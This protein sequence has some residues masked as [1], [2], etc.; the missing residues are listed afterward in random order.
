MKPDMDSKRPNDRDDRRRA[1]EETDQSFIMEASAGTG[2]THTLINRILHLILEKGP[3]GRPLRLLEIC[4]ITFTEKAA[5]E[6][7][8]RLRQYL[9]QKLPEYRTAPVYQER[10]RQALEDLEI[11]SISTFHAFAVGLL[12]ERPIEA[13]L[14][15]RFSA[16]DEIQSEFYFRETWESWISRMLE[17]RDPVLE[18]ALRNGLRLKNLEALARILRLHWIAIRD[19]K[20]ATPPSDEEFCGNLQTIQSRS[21]E[22]VS[23]I[24]DPEDKLARFL[25]KTMSWLLH[26]DPETALDKPGRLGAA[27]KWHGGKDTVERVQAFLREVMELSESY[28]MLPMQRLLDEVV[29]WMIQEFVKGEWEK[30]KKADGYL[31]FDDQLYQARELLRHHSSVRNDFQDRYRTLLVDEFQDTDSIQ[32]EIVLLLSSKEPWQGDAA[33]LLP[34]PGRLF[35][36]GDP[37]QSIYRFRNADIETYLGFVDENSLKTKRIEKVRL[38]ANFRSVPSILN[39]VDAAFEKAMQLPED[40]GKYQPPYA[41]FAGQGA[42]EQDPHYPAVHLLNDSADRGDTKKNV[43]EF[44]EAEAQRIAKLIARVCGSGSWKIQ[45]SKDNNQWRAPQFGDIAI[46]LPVLSHADILEDE[47]CKQNIPYVL[48]GGKFYY[49]RS[50]VGSAITVLRAVSNPNDHVA[51]YGALRSIF[52]G[53]SDEDLL[54]ARMEGLELDYRAPVPETSPLHPVFEILRD[55]HRHR[56]ERRASETFEVLLQKTG[57][58]EV[59]AVRGYQTLAN[60]N[61]VGRTLRTLQGDAAFSQ[62]IDLLSSMDE[63]GLAESESRLMEERSEA[64]RMMSIHKSK[65][66]DFPIVIVAS[67]GLKKQSRAKAFLTDVHEGKIFSLKIGS[68]ESGLQMA[69]WDELTEKEKKREEAELVRLL[70]VGLTRARDHLILS[71][72]TGGMKRG[73]DGDRFIPDMEGTRLKPLAPF[74]QECFS[75]KSGLTQ[76]IDVAAIDA[77]I[78]CRKTVDAPSIKDWGGIADREFC[79][80]RSLLVNT[81]AS[82]KLRIAGESAELEQEDVAS[83]S[84]MMETAQKRSVRLG[85]A[86]H[87]AMERVDFFHRDGLEALLRKLSVR[88]GLDSESV[89]KLR[90]M[91]DGC[92]SSVLMERVLIAGRSGKRILREVPYVRSMKDSGIEEGKIDLLFE[93]EAGWV[94]VDYK[95]DWVSHDKESREAFFREKYF[96]QMLE[97]AEALKSLALK[98]SSAYLLLARTGDSIKIL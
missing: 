56:H 8:V 43:R 38:V 24:K 49:S 52:F 9:E 95:T 61:K 40:G 4:A 22:L 79:E 26:P 94:V 33:R 69:G 11:A 3:G 83:E 78:V 50:E 66:L 1:V 19:L 88:Y 48:E 90:E 30:K 60:L 5:G 89:D 91:I 37:K 80:L 86:F 92:L 31:D 23:L 46:L 2:K 51:L 41:P 64:V 76:L 7:K 18:K 59:L 21:V 15:P 16:L 6:M 32:L 96:H 36:V 87:E 12:K 77:T 25:E 93:E 29:R 44:I 28:K 97:Y 53:F 85:T 84:R 55:L 82:G 71:A 62:V 58:R 47:L 73:E 67:L 70:Y 98:V 10:V 57:A 13:G 63:E 39:F 65:G 14:D 17:Q 34:N 20:C 81:P 42:R 75:G 68:R 54:K 72:H 74:L 45:D 27:G 35:I